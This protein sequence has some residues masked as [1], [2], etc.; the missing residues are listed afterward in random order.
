MRCARFKVFGRLDGA[1]GARQGTVTIE[2]GFSESLVHVRPFRR[3]RVY[4]MPLS[5]VA[6]FICQRILLGELAERRAKKAKARRS[7]VLPRRAR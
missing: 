4:T 6:D 5:Q 7:R 2:R 3:K 1:G